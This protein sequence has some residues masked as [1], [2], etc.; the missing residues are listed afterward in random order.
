MMMNYQQAH[1][2]HTSHQ[3]H[4]CTDSEVVCR[5]LCVSV[6]RQDCCCTAGHS[7]T[8]PDN[9]PA[10]LHWDLCWTALRLEVLEEV[11]AVMILPRSPP[12]ISSHSRLPQVDSALV[13]MSVKNL[14]YWKV[15]IITS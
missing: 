2:Q 11:V 10:T 5:L 7:Q 6:C 9:H 3:S 14:K 15:N 8:P 13:K 1:H 4:L 12:L